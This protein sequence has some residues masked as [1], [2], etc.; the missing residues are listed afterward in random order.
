[1]K[2]KIR[3]RIKQEKRELKELEKQRKDLTDV[4]DK[5]FRWKLV[6]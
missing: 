1:L 3:V 4:V 5:M 6:R 2:E